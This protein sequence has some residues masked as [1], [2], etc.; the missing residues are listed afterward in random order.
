[1]L[2]HTSPT[3][4]DFL[5]TSSTYKNNLKYLINKTKNYDYFSRNALILKLEFYNHLLNMFDKNVVDSFSLNDK[6]VAI[7]KDLH[8]PLPR[9]TE[10][11]NATC[12]CLGSSIFF[13]Q[14]KRHRMSSMFP[15]HYFP[16]FGATIP[17]IFKLCNLKDEFM[18][19]WW[20]AVYL[21]IQI[22]NE[23][24]NE[25]VA[26][27][28]LP[29]ATRKPVLFQMNMR[30]LHHFISLRADKHAGKGIRFFAKQLNKELQ[31]QNIFKNLHSLFKGKE[32]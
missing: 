32:H 9:Y 28:I 22:F 8:S 7:E 19:C 12:L 18:Y 27:Y 10:F 30:E 1:L 3:A 21:Y 5:L 17:T 25:D 15:Q 2:R 31:H 13:A 20:K 14:L 16:Y 11:G 24:K 6:L 26:N 4:Y 29:C 23:T